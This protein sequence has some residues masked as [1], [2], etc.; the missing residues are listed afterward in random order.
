MERIELLI[1]FHF[2]TIMRQD[3]IYSSYEYFSTY[4]LFVSYIMQSSLN[5]SFYNKRRKRYCKL[6]DFN[7]AFLKS[8]NDLLSNK[9]LRYVKKKYNC[10]YSFFFY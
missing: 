9:K 2:A 3:A 8:V 4:F 10:H 7:I 5:Y 6:R 1:I